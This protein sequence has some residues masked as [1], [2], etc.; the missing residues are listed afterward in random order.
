MS[1]SRKQHSSALLLGEIAT[2]LLYLKLQ[3]FPFRG[4]HPGA[5][6]RKMH[7]ELPEKIFCAGMLLPGGK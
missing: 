2:D 1:N 3:Y 5:V 4:R 7:V 6:I